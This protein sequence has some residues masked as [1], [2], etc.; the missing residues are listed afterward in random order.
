M[1]LAERSTSVTPLQP[2]VSY[3]YSQRLIRASVDYK[4]LASTPRARPEAKTF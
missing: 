4:R 3:I 1:G 2:M